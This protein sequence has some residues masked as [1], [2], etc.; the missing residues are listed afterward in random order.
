LACESDTAIDVVKD[1]IG[2]YHLA[3][4]ARSS[5]GS[6]PL[7]IA[8]GRKAHLSLLKALIKGHAAAL[9]VEDNRGRI[10][11]HIAVA[12]QADYKTVR[13]LVKYCQDGIRVKNNLN[14]TPLQTAEKRNVEFDERVLE[15]LRPYID[16]NDSDQ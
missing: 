1:M 10:P 12:V 4:V 5:D 9:K 7:H 2:G 16:P 8:V 3:C 11:L 13:L 14:Q 15:L 6:T